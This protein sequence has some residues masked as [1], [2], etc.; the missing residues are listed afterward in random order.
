MKK[1]LIKY[2]PI[3]R[4]IFYIALFSVFI[5]IP[6]DKVESGSLCAFYNIF[7]VLCF[8][9]GTTRAFSN[10]MHLRFSKALAYNPLFT[11]M[12]CPIFTILFIQDSFVIIKRM[13]TKKECYS[14]IEVFIRGII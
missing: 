14:M 7:N 11:L 9:C 8:S 12:I 2:F 1:M 6:C 3:A 10:I 5:I 13:L 4:L